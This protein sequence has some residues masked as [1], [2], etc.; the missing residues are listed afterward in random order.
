MDTIKKDWIE[1]KVPDLPFVII[2]QQELKDHIGEKLSNIDGE[3]MV[4]SIIQAQYGDGKTNVLK[5]L[6]LYFGN[7]P[8][9]GVHMLYSRADV[10]QTDFCKYLLQQLQDNC[11]NELVSGVNLLRKLRGFNPDILANNF[12]DD[13]S[14]IREYTE[15]LF[16]QGQDDEIIKNLISRN[17]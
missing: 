3:R 15:K 11:I 8:E 13:F 17:W 2:D 1:G 7:H 14:H 9:L 16:E 4:T 12:N 6:S 10:E 5:Y